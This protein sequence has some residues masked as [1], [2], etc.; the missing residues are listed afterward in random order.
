MNKIETSDVYEDFGVCITE[1]LALVIILLNQDFM[2][3]QTY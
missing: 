1:H 2:I 3:I